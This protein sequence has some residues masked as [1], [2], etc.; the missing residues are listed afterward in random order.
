MPLS[1]CVPHLSYLDRVQL[2]VRDVQTL[3]S[4]QAEKTLVL[5]GL[6]GVPGDGELPQ[7]GHD[8]PHHAGGAGQV[9]VGQVQAP[10]GG[11]V[12]QGGG[13]HECEFIGGH[14]ELDEFGEV[15]AGEDG[16]GGVGEVQVLQAVHQ[17]LEDVAGDNLQWVV[18]QREVGQGWRTTECLLVNLI[19]G[20]ERQVQV[21]D[22]LYLVEESVGDQ[23]DPVARQVQVLQTAL[24][25]VESLHWDFVEFIE[26]HSENFQFGLTEETFG[27]IFNFVEG[28]IKNSQ[29]FLSIQ[30]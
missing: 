3:Q 1:Q 6:D 28:E 7:P 30:H 22:V 9:V 4:V 13:R 18:G 21:D 11:H 26:S 5:E 10:Q 23:L 15:K 29:V 2:H 16:E 25:R 12:G 20:V 8:V 24:N 27:E 19:D 17:P 14:V